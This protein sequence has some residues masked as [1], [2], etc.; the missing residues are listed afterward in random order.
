MKGRSDRRPSQ[1]KPDVRTSVGQ[2]NHLRPTLNVVIENQRQTAIVVQDVRLM[3]AEPYGVPLESR[4]NL[5]KR[6]LPGHT[7]Q[8]SF[9]AE[10]VSKSLEVFFHPRESITVQPSMLEATPRCILGSNEFFL[11]DPISVS[12][13]SSRYTAEV[14]SNTENVN[15]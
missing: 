13:D 2:V 15:E 4:A 10:T 11:G 3:F 9:S 8:F 12:T 7:E 14:S 5:N 6:V 1:P